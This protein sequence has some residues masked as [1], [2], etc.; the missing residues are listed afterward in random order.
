MPSPGSASGLSVYFGSL[1]DSRKEAARVDSSIADFVDSACR[2]AHEFS[3]RMRR[4]CF[5]VVGI[6]KA[7]RIEV[8]SWLV[9]AFEILGFSDSHLHETSVILDRY[10]AAATGVE[11]NDES[12]SQQKLLAAVCI[13]LKMGPQEAL[14]APLKQ[15]ITQLGRGK[16]PFAAVLRTE[17]VVLHNLKFAVGA[18]TV[19]DFIMGLS[20]R[21][22]K[23]AST[24][25]KFANFLAQ[26]ALADEDL[27]YNYPHSVFAAAALVLAL[28]VYEAPAEAYISVKDD[29]ALHCKSK[30]DGEK[31]IQQVVPC[32][33]QIHRFWIECIGRS[34]DVDKSSGAVPPRSNEKVVRQSYAKHVLN[35][36]GRSEDEGRPRYA[37]YG[38]DPFSRK[39]T[40]PPTFAPKMVPPRME[41]QEAMLVVH[42]CTPGKATGEFDAKTLLGL[43]T[44]A[45]THSEV[46]RILVSHGWQ[47]GSFRRRNPAAAH[48]LFQ[49]FSFAAS[50]KASEDCRSSPISGASLSSTPQRASPSHLSPPR[51]TKNVRMTPPKTVVYQAKSPSRE[52]ALS[53]GYS[54]GRSTGVRELV[55]FA[56]NSST[57]CRK[58]IK[59]VPDRSWRRGTTLIGAG[60]LPPPR[61]V[62]FRDRAASCG[63]VCV[64]SVT[65]PG[66]LQFGPRETVRRRSGCTSF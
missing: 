1:Q 14:E 33:E 47:G 26:L 37:K 52:R 63:R 64:G 59:G 2:S 61:S 57:D 34:Q 27:F 24:A 7:D 23:W 18:P 4:T 22:Q 3:E 58:T 42:Q 30:P 20:V 8:L 19:Y 10:H 50:N 41:M 51:S 11:T 43:R 31:L 62:Q 35:K 53:T 66:H 54:S 13:S 56:V 40:S 32:C 12:S 38:S 60:A 25:Q 29:L 65:R 49:D 55:H 28:F 15:L 39:Y 9:Q 17:I 21:L 5:P 6:G 16:V 44:L 48:L 45:E 46:R 36:F